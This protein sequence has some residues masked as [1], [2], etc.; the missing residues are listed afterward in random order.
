[1]HV[2]HLQLGQQRVADELPERA[3]DAQ[4]RARRLDRLDG[5]GQVDALGLQ[6]LE[7]ELGCRR[8][9]RA[10]RPGGGRGRA[11]GRAA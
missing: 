8:P 10:G 6:Q 2:Q 11:G 5:V 7:P 9:P 3:D 4:V 1:M